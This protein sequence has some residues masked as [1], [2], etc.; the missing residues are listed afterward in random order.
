MREATTLFSP[1]LNRQQVKNRAAVALDNLWLGFDLLFD[2]LPTLNL[3]Q[4]DIARDFPLFQQFFNLFFIRR[5]QAEFVA[6]FAGH[7]G[8]YFTHG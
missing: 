1:E 6:V 2:L 4:D 7:V 5:H 8:N 3:F